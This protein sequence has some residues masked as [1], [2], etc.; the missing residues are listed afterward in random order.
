MSTDES[1]IIRHCAF[2]RVPVSGQKN[3]ALWKGKR[4]A[5]C[6]QACQKLDWS[7]KTVM[8]KGTKTG[9]GWDTGRKMSTSKWLLSLERDLST[10]RQTLAY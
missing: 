6:S 5:Y 8:D 9:A 1:Q 2:C 10:Y 3:P 4:R 7:L